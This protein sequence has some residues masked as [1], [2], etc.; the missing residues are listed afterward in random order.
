MKK[1]IL[2]LTIVVLLLALVAC[3]GGGN[4][5]PVVENNAAAVDNAAAPADDAADEAMAEPLKVAFVYVAPIGDLGWT[6][7]HDQA[8]LLLEENFGDQ[9]ETAFIE[10]V[11][12][13]P[14]SERVIRDFATKGYDLIITTSFGYMD[15]TVAVA[16]EFPDIQFVHISGY[17]TADNVSTVFGRMYQPRYLSGLVAGAA[18]ESNIVGY[19]AAFPIPEVIRGINAFTLGV[20]EVNPDA[21]VRVVWTNTWFDPPQEKEGAEALLSAG[22]DVIAQH[23]DTTEPQKAAADSGAQ[24][25]GYD[26]DMRPFVGETVLT[27]PVWH[28]EVKY[29]DIV[30]QLIA[31]TY[32]GSESY[33]GGLT[34]GVVGLAPFSDQVSQETKDLVAEKQ[35]LIE[36]GE[37]DVFCGPLVGANG[38]L[39]VEEGK[40]LTDAEMLSMDFF[41]EGVSG[42]APAEAPTGLGE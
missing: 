22:A 40:C 14:E 20:R 19:V 24:S 4:E 36:S 11:P 23:Q 37:W 2:W 33:W 21:E 29:G 12:E 9:I 18:T 8:R 30:E 26:S 41:V 16:S 38:N 7:A 15:P 17:K 25:I 13:G 32:N 5:E 10:N 42:E 3:G 6:W 34:D 39:V 27:S 1:R 35:A 31:G 28:W